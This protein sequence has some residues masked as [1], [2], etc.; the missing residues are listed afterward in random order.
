MENGY[1]AAASLL[2][3]G[4]RRAALALAPERQA[5]AEEF[6]LRAGWRAAVLLPEGELPLPEAPEVTE[7]VLRDVLELATGASAHTAA[8]Q[9]RHGCVT[10]AGGCRVGFCGEGVLEGGALR[11]LRRLRS[12]AIRIPRQALGCADG[13]F[14]ALGG[15]DFRSALLLSPPGGGKTTLAREL[16]RLLSEAGLRVAVADER[17]ELAI[18][19][20][21]LGARADVLSGVP[22]AEAAMLLLRAMN[23]QVI[24]M[25]EIT[26]PED[27]EAIELA[28]G[29]GAALLATA[30]APDTAALRARPLYRRL[31]ASEVF[32]QAVVIRRMPDGSREYRR[33]A[34][35]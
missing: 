16:I 1:R 8:E 13:L 7:A 35:P 2:P 3:A 14:P 27:L 20:T 18:S 11:T 34:L 10:A 32:R 6:R 28:A 25:D 30:H 12:A 17:G 19:P 4:W 5:K 21:A 23:P 33:E 15:R 22:K 31:L 26:S 9:L 24:A 29:C